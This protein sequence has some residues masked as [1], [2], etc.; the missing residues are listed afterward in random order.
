MPVVNARSGGRE[1]KRFGVG[2]LLRSLRT[3]HTVT[4]AL[5]GM[6]MLL[7]YTLLCILYV[8]VLLYFTLLCT[9]MHCF[10]E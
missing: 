7:H 1:G 8:H 9:R 10:I 5:Q 6:L 3:R 2:P 4:A